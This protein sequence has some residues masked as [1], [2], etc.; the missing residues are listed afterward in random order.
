MRKLAKDE[1]LQ[2]RGSGRRRVGCNGKL[3]GVLVDGQKITVQ[4]YPVFAAFAVK[5]ETVVAAINYDVPVEPALKLGDPKAVQP[6]A[7]TAV[8]NEQ[9]LLT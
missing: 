2:A 4:I 1:G 6:A 7:K 5:N 8:R 3:G 9:E